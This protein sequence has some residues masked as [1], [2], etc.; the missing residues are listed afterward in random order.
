MYNEDDLLPLAGLQHLAFCERQCAL[1]YLEN[2]W[3]ENVLTTEGG[4]L[5][6]RVDEPA[7]EVR[8]NLRIARALRLRS[9]RLGISG[10]A[11]VVEFHKA[12]DQAGVA[13]SGV[14]GS[15]QPLPVEYKRGRPKSHRADE[16]QL[17][18]QALCLEEMLGVTVP[19]G[20]LY[21]D[22]PKRRVDV[23]FDD[24]LRRETESLAERLHALIGAGTTPPARY[25]K[26]CRSCSLLP[27]CMP[28]VAGRSARA[29]LTRA[30]DDA[31]AA[32]DGEP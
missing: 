1:M 7:T 10:R 28:K 26:R 30:I 8:G 12:A 22:T 31:I 23:E 25:E 4:I 2:E 17:C 5:H 9:L 3:A 6:E 20:A 13:L 14:R 18:A 11:D 32:M 21:Y 27:V 29:Y 24:V 16:A 15:W 19:K